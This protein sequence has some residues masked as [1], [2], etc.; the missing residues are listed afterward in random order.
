MLDREARVL[1]HKL[2]RLAKLRIDHDGTSKVHRHLL[3]LTTRNGYDSIDHPGGIF[4]KFQFSGVSVADF[5]LI[6]AQ[7]SEGI[8]EQKREAGLVQGLKPF[9][10]GSVPMVDQGVLLKQ[11]ETKHSIAKSQY[12]VRG[13]LNLAEAR[14]LCFE[15][16]RHSP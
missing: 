16:G 10:S 14:G 8:H 7:K 5:E 6:S 13:V 4:R 3:R 11:R 15:L 9:E 2:S 1:N 12:I